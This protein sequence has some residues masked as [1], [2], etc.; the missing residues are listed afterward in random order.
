MGGDAGG[1]GAAAAAGPVIAPGDA[2]A[3]EAYVAAAAAAGEE[4]AYDMIDFLTP[5]HTEIL[6]SSSSPSPLTPIRASVLFYPTW[7]RQF[8]CGTTPPVLG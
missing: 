8:S 2:A 6:I 4:G 1:G 3:A 5:V 7:R